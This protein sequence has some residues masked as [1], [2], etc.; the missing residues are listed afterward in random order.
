VTHVLTDAL[1]FSRE[2]GTQL[3]LQ[4]DTA[5]I[6]EQCLEISGI[7]DVF[8]VVHNRREALAA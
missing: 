6:V 7:L 4:M 8:D 1:K 5:L 2:C 3:R